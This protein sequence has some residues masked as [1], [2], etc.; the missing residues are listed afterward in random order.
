MSSYPSLSLLEVFPPSCVNLC[1]PHWLLCHQIISTPQGSCFNYSRSWFT[2]TLSNTILTLGDF[3]IHRDDPSNTQASQSLE[4]LSSNDFPST[5]LIVMITHNCNASVISISC[6]PLS[7][8]NLLFFQLT[9]L[10]N[11]NHPLTPP[12]P[13]IC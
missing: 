8:P 4:F 11:S 12:E 9:S 5:R 7:D 3:N 13:P 2:I 1:T 10:P 6:I